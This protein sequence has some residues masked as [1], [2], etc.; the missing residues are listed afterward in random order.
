MKRNDIH[1]P[2]SINP[3]DYTFVAFECIKIEGMGDVDV[4][5]HNRE[6]IREHMAR[7][8]GT[9]SGHEHGGNC[10]VCGAHAVYTVLFYNQPTN[11][12]IRTGQDCAD[13]MEMGYGD[14]NAFRK[15]LTAQAGKRKAQAL[16]ADA[17]LARAW[18]VFVAGY[19]RHELP[20]GCIWGTGGDFVTQADG[21]PTTPTQDAAFRDIYWAHAKRHKPEATIIDIVGGLVKCGSISD[22]ATKYLGVLLQQIENRPEIE[23]KRAAEQAAAANCPAGRIEVQGRIASVK[24]QDS[25]FGS[26]TKILVIH[27]TS[28]KVWGTRP[29]APAE[30]DRCFEVGDIIKFKATVTVSDKDPKFGY[31]KRPGIGI[32]VAAREEKAR[33]AQ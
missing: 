11:T 31:Y 5:L 14:M 9:Y 30:M 6:L 17:G 33:A 20:E 12:Y 1:K 28:Y 23:A 7:T 21:S 18:E 10:M 26:V 8:G 16:L 27:E 15:A 19:P 32:L 4:V 2:S 13:K 29:Q 3:A 24:V 25:D 22:A